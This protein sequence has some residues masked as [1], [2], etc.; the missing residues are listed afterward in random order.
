MARRAERVVMW[1]CFA[2]AALCVVVASCYAHT[3]TPSCAADPNQV[4]C[5]HPVHDRKADGGR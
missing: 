5:V 1:L 4:E 2:G 3:P